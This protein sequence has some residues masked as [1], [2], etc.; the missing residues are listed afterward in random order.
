MGGK[1]REQIRGHPPTASSSPW[2]RIRIPD[3]HQP[4]VQPPT[5]QRYQPTDRRILYFLTESVWPSSTVPSQR[6][7]DGLRLDRR[8]LYFFRGNIHSGSIRQ[9]LLTLENTT[10]I[11]YFFLL[12][13]SICPHAGMNINIR[14]TYSLLLQ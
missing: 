7:A 5:Y 8:I 2:F 1:G 3:L 12:P 14:H 9:T 13:P 4:H 10:K 6:T 11:P